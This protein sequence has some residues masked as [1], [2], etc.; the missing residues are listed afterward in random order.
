MPKSLRRASVSSIGWAE[1]IKEFEGDLGSV[2]VSGE[3]ELVDLDDERSP[4]PTPIRNMSRVFAHFP[5]LLEV[6]AEDENPAAD[7]VSSNMDDGIEGTSR[8]SSDVDP[9]PPQNVVVVSG[10]WEHALQVM[11]EFEQE[12]QM[13]NSSSSRASTARRSFRPR[14]WSKSSSRASSNH[15]EGCV[16]DELR[17]ACKLAVM[18]AGI[19]ENRRRRTRSGSDYTLRGFI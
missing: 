1:S 8:T 16:D 2:H 9:P 10:Q 6:A 19:L 15:P 4:S 18:S 3:R 13:R 12:A 11:Q 14:T 17:E 7:T 5:E